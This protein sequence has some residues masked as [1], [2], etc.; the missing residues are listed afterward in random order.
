[1]LDGEQRWSGEVLGWYGGSD[2]WHGVV[3]FTKWTSQ[4]WPMTYKHASP[5]SALE[6]R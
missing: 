2:G 1:M 5:P 4:G 6:P 3:R